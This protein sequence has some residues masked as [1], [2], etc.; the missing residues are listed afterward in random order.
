MFA[1]LNLVKG[2]YSKADSYLLELCQRILLDLYVC[3]CA[4]AHLFA[5]THLYNATHMQTRPHA[6]NWES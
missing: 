5:H 1:K 3:V 6:Q 2:N 4:S